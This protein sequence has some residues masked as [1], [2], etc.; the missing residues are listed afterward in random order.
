MAKTVLKLSIDEFDFILAGIICQH[1]DYRLCRELN[2]KLNI[3]L[4]KKDDYSVFNNKRMEDHA[5]SF[6]EYVNDDEDRFNL[7]ANKCS[8]GILLPEQK[9]IDYLFLLKPNRMRI[10]ENELISQLKSIA[11]ILGVYKMDVPALKSKDN[12]VF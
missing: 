11:L 9:Q 5:F 7:I 3:H 4:V 10:E 6:Y 12:L 8:R 1:K 2:L